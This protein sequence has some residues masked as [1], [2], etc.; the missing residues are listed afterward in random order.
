MIRAIIRSGAIHP[1]EDLPESWKEGQ[2]LIVEEGEPPF[3]PEE[4]IAWSREI[5]E[6]AAEIPQEEHDR[7][8]AALEA[9][10]RESKRF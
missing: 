8:L 1:L 7:F 9:L 10:E 4:I 5:E 3:D 2:E 6:T